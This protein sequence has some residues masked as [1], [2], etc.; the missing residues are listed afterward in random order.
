M[1]VWETP[2]RAKTRRAASTMRCRVLRESSL[3][4]RMTVRGPG[5]L[6]TVVIVYIM[7]PPRIPLGVSPMKNLVLPVLLAAFIAGC[8]SKANTPPPAPAAVPA[9]VVEV[10]PR[11]VPIVVEGVGQVE[12]S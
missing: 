2:R 9:K 7:I 1:L 6:D 3:E 10:Q 12:G 11:T 8:N 4:R 5:H